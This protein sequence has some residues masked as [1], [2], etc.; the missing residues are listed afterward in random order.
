VIVTLLWQPLCNALSA[1]GWTIH[2]S[3]CLLALLHCRHTALLGVACGPT[4]TQLIFFSFWKIAPLCS[5]ETPKKS[6]PRSGIFPFSA[7]TEGHNAERGRRS[8]PCSRNGRRQSTVPSVASLLPCFDVGL[9]DFRHWNIKIK[10]NCRVVL[11]YTN[12]NQH[13]Y[14]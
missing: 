14:D 13:V 6:V 5:P 4:I 10:R 3:K 8:W 1:P 7:W 11:F 12:S 2:L 9:R